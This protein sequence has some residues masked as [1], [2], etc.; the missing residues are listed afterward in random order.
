MNWT[1]PLGRTAIAAGLIAGLVAVPTTHVAAATAITAPAT[2]YYGV[3][4]PDTP[5]S[6]AFDTDAA[7]AITR[8]ELAD[9]IVAADCAAGASTLPTTV[10]GGDA[11]IEA[12][13]PASTTVTC[14][15]T[16]DLA[17][18]VT[19][20]ATASLDVIE[21]DVFS[22]EIARGTT[23]VAL[24]AVGVTTVAGDVEL[25]AGTYQPYFPRSIGDTLTYSFDVTADAS[26]PLSVETAAGAA[27]TG[28]PAATTTTLTCAIDRTLSAGD[29]TDEIAP[30]SAVVLAGGFPVA[31]FERDVAVFAERR[32]GLDLTIDPP[33]PSVGDHLSVS[34][35]LENQGSVE[36]TDVVVDGGK[37]G[38]LDCEGQPVADLVLLPSTSVV[39]TSARTLH[40][41]DL[42]PNTPVLVRATSAVPG[43][44]DNVDDDPTTDTDV[45][46]SLPTPF[47]IGEP[48]ID[49]IVAV[50]DA[51]VWLPA[52]ADP[53][54]ARL[55]ETAGT[56][57]VATA[58]KPA[59]LRVELPLE[60]APGVRLTD[61]DDVVVDQWC[62][63]DFSTDLFGW[64]SGVAMER[65]FTVALDSSLMPDGGVVD[66]EIGGLVVA[67]NGIRM[68][69]TATTV[70]TAGV[71]AGL[72]R[73][74]LDVTGD[75]VGTELTISTMPGAPVD[76]VVVPA[77]GATLDACSTAAGA[78]ALSE[79]A[80]RYALGS[81]GPSTDITCTV[82]SPVSDGDRSSSTFD[83]ALDLLAT[84]GGTTHEVP[85]AATIASRAIT[86]TAL[87]PSPVP[88]NGYHPDG[89]GGR[90]S[91]VSQT[92]EVRVLGDAG[93]S[94]SDPQTNTS[95]ASATVACTAL[96]ATAWTC[97]VERDVTATEMDAGSI[98]FDLAA[99]VTVDG[100]E[101]SASADASAEVAF[102][103]VEVTLT[104]V[105]SP[106]LPSGYW[107]GETIQL[108]V[109]VRNTGSMP[110]TFGGIGI[111]GAAESQSL[112][113]FTRVGDDIVVQPGET[114]EESFAVTVSAAQ[115]E[116]DGATLSF[117]VGNGVTV[118]TASIRLAVTLDDPPPAVDPTPAEPIGDLG[119]PGG[120]VTEL[121]ATGSGSLAMASVAGLLLAL[122]LVVRRRFARP[123]L[124]L[125]ITDA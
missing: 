50:S 23:T 111:D 109:Q 42:G 4:G 53:A 73:A 36:L 94:I 15:L 5:L 103:S 118:E 101:L 32:I 66:L 89:E 124:H 102:E 25:A 35:T 59:F 6:I 119:Q 18:P 106:Q 105:S 78:V 28:C 71:G 20:P 115:V 48:D 112:R 9:T 83:V 16:L 74:P 54:A 40:V 55:G 26:V 82:T 117:T 44:S 104:E 2:V 30:M 122:G 67:D 85:V 123:T 98:E 88:A 121:P 24:T 90:P 86:V 43:D 114:Y 64:Q 91:T 7:P 29:L 17:G 92:F 80:G 58:V 125:T 14:D 69:A 39:C 22:Q 68:D 113:S 96:D 57:T 81:I 37:L 60:P 97:T 75:D 99:A 79:G 31:E 87:D 27:A 52:G 49:A 21:H 46:A 10:L 107:I 84:A 110:V 11:I 72:D 51:V 65:T 41:D 1:H 56:I 70:S 108:L 38:N 120:P 45:D 93:T 3:G 13:L 47:E 34:L 62:R 63:M 8:V 95:D 33:A 61:C 77:G 100:M 116:A 76:L 19:P 12:N